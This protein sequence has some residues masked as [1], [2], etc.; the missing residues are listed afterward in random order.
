LI[1]VP[2]RGRTQRVTPDTAVYD[3]VVTR[4]R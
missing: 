3:P 2:R 1:A 4:R